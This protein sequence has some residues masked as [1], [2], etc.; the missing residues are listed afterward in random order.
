MGF[1]PGNVTLELFDKP[2]CEGKPVQE[3]LAK[4]TDERFLIRVENTE[5][6]SI[7][8]T[9]EEYETLCQDIGQMVPF[10]TNGIGI[11]I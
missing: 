1:G 6:W 8:A 9:S 4:N 3:K 5:T 7:R 10:N 11:Y 2:L